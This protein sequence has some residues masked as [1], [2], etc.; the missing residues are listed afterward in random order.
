VL[1]FWHLKFDG[2]KNTCRWYGLPYQQRVIIFRQTQPIHSKS[3]WFEDY[4]FCSQPRK[5]QL[6]L[7]EMLKR[8]DFYAHTQI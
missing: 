8:E 2:L 7:P 6:A 4:L 1:S 3:F 5:S